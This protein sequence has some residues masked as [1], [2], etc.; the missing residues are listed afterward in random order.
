MATIGGTMATAGDVR[1]EQAEARVIE[2]RRRLE[3]ERK[4]RCPRPA[5]VPATGDGGVVVGVLRPLAADAVAATAVPRG[6]AHMR[7]VAAHSLGPRERRGVK[8]DGER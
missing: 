4:M 1:K 2:R 5:R 8:H 7:N 3:E 6:P